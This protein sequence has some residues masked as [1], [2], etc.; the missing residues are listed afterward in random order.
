MKT[1]IILAVAVITLLA[2]CA[3]QDLSKLT[4]EERAVVLQRQALADQRRSDALAKAEGITLDLLGGLASSLNSRGLGQG[5]E[6][7]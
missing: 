1:L 6:G 4:P 7:K 5:R 2:G 3:T